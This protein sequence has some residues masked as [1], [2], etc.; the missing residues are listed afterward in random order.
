[1]PAY[2]IYPGS[3]P[4]INPYA[5]IVNP[6]MPKAPGVPDNLAGMPSATAVDDLLSSSWYTYLQDNVNFFNEQDVRNEATTPTLSTLIGNADNLAASLK[7]S[8]TP[9]WLTIALLAGAGFLGYKLLTGFSST[10]HVSRF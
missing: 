8:L 5:G 9:S 7:D 2:S 4:N 10:Y 6:P 1:M 3:N